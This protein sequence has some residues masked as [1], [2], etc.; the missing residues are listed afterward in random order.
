MQNPH[1]SDELFFGDQ[2]ECFA[3]I[4][5]CDIP[6][7][8]SKGRMFWEFPDSGNAAGITF[9]RWDQ[10]NGVGVA[11]SVGSELNRWEYPNSGYSKRLNFVNWIM[12]NCHI[13]NDLILS[14]GSGG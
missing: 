10:T 2:K 5:N 7:E 9:F 3:N 1:T 14:S 4:S 8:L 12:T 6:D 11:G 13:L